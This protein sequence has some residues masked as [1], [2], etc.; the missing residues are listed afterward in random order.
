M[1]RVLE[2]MQEYLKISMILSGFGLLKEIRPSEPFITNFI[3]DFKNVS[4]ETINQDIF[5]IGTYSHL[6]QLVIIFLV[7]DWLR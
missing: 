4:I 7:T 3:T 6:A 1:S 2:K 5:P